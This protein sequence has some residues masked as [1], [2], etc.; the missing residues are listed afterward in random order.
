MDKRFGDYL[1][2]FNTVADSTA[3]IQLEEYKPNHL[4]YTSTSSTSNLAVFSEVYYR[5]ESDW[6]AYI[7]GEE[8][9]HI[10]VNY[11]LRGLKVPAGQHKI[12]FKFAPPTYF[13]GT[14]VSL[15][16][17]VLIILLML[18]AIAQWWR[19]KMMVENEE[20]KS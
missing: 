6:K 10:R 1:S 15:I 14:A 2:G 5:G 9:P 20:E 3:R 8:V 18:G 4:T 7:D 17:S 16:S 11:I 13:R 12:E 19:G